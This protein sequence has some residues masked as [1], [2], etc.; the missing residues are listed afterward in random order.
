[1]L[2]NMDHFHI[3]RMFTLEHFFFLR[4]R[5]YPISYIYIMINTEVKLTTYVSAISSD[6]ALINKTNVL[7]CA[8]SLTLS[9][10]QHLQHFTNLEVYHW[11]GR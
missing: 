7:V 4:I 9:K 5:T 3:M 1:M 10:K 11:L 6:K 2:W 8:V